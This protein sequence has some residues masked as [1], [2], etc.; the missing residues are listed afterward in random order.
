MYMC[1]ILKLVRILVGHCVE[2]ISGANQR[3]KV[4]KTE[5]LVFCVSVNG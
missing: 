5:T 4:S 2:I 3:E 1:Y